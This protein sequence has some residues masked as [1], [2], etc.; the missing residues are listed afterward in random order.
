MRS[1]NQGNVSELGVEALKYPRMSVRRVCLARR[2]FSS[3][4]I[5][6]PSP[7]P[8]RLPCNHATPAL[9]AW[10]RYDDLIWPSLA[11]KVRVD[12]LLSAS[13]FNHSPGP[14]NPSRRT[15]NKAFFPAIAASRR[16]IASTDDTGAIVR[17]RRDHHFM[18]RH[19]DEC[20]FPR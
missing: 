4:V 9:R 17:R 12:L 6:P 1:Q 13:V 7:L 10:Q 14:R 8:L 5:D 20:G 11:N 15:G 19:E 2:V 16:R 18:D 3:S